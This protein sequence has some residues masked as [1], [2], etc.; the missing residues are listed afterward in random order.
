MVSC[1]VFGHLVSVAQQGLAPE[2]RGL[3]HV[4]HVIWLPTKTQLG[5]FDWIRILKT[6]CLVYISVSHTLTSSLVVSLRHTNST[7]VMTPAMER[8]GVG[9]VTKVVMEV[10]YALTQAL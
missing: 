1:I 2:K 5:P 6:Q 4:V 8:R 9:E 3:S 10:T 7:L